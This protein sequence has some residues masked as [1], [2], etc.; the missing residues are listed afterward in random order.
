M[1]IEKL[2]KKFDLEIEQIDQD[3]DSLDSSKD[4]EYWLLLGKAES[5]GNCIFYIIEEYSKTNKL[6][7]YLESYL[8]IYKIK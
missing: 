4:A 8:D 5:L 6:T 7:E 3:K 1:E 2:I